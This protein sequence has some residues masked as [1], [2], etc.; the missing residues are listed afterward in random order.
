VEN[1]ADRAWSFRYGYQVIDR[2]GTGGGNFRALYA[3]FL[4]EAEAAVPG[5]ARLG[6]SP[7]MRA[8]AAAWSR[9]AAMMK[10]ISEVPGGLVPPQAREQVRAIARDERRYHEDVAAW[11]R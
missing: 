6:L 7:R 9:L 2:R 1:E 8:L 4:E 3:R 11:V 5:L 10:A